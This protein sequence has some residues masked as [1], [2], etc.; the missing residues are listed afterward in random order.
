MDSKTDLSPGTGPKIDPDTNPID[1]LRDLQKRMAD[2]I[3]SDADLERIPG[4]RLTAL[5][6]YVA[7]DDFLESVAKN[8]RSR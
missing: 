7:M 1:T 5:S 6:T 2:M 8:V 3:N 4:G